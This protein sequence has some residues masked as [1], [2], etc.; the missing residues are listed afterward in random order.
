MFVCI[1]IGLFSGLITVRFGGLD[2]G[3]GTGDG[4]LIPGIVTGFLRSVRWAM[5]APTLSRTSC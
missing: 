2:I 3:L 5:P 4:L 1:A